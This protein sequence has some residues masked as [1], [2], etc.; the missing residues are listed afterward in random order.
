VIRPSLIA[1]CL[2][3]GLLVGAC[4]T[5]EPARPAEGPSPAS[6]EALA[7]LALQD[8]TISSAELVAA[9]AF[10][11]PGKPGAPSQPFDDLPAFCR[12]VASARPVP[13]DVKIEVWLPAANWNGDFQPAGSPYWGGSIPYARMRALLK[14]G[15]ATVGTNL[16]VEGFTGPSFV[17]EH[18]EKLAYLANLPFH[19][20]IERG[21]AVVDAYYGTGPT[22]TVMDECGGGGSRDVLSTVQRWPGD[23]DLASA[24]GST[25]YG[26]RHGIAQ[27]WVYRATHKNAASYV[28]PSKYPVIHKAALA[29]C[30]MDDG[31]KDGLIEDPLRCKV[32]LAPVMCKGADGPDCLTKAQSEA[33]RTIYTTPRHAKTGEPI[34]GP[35]VPGGELGWEHIAG[36]T[37]Y[38]YSQS[39]YRNLVFHGDPQ[40]NWDKTPVNFDSHIDAVETPDRLIINATNPDIRPFIERGGK[41]LMV[42]GWAEATLSTVNN[43]SYYESVV[44]ALGEETTRNAVR[45]FMVPGM[46]HCFGDPYETAPTFHASPV[47]ILKQWKS[48]GKAPDEIIVTYQRTGEAERRRKVCAYPRV[49]HYGGSGDPA[50]PANYSCR[51]PE[52]RP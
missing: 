7:K 28:P 52:D 24:V 1:L 19:T 5:K 18:P 31:V 49:A 47:D 12:V 35:M 17:P 13:D 30:D 42:G 10:A 8:T 33:V 26:T 48:T 25:N 11:P 44:K 14:K 34:Y 32:D 43:I 15:A 39:F 6:C 45:L 41:L 50:D 22:L 46:D 37:P 20:A 16:G 4:E 3:G 36:P 29:S 9:G 40:W 38:P 23:L 51:L 2:M 27:M 21:K